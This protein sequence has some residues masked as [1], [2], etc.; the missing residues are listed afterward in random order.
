MSSIGAKARQ[1]IRSRRS[2]WPLTAI[3]SG[4]EKYLR[5]YYNDSFFD[6]ALNGEAYVINSYKEL[7]GGKDITIW[8]IGANNGQWAEMI[9]NHFPA[10]KIISFEI[11]PQIA[12]LLNKKFADSEWVEIHNLGLSDS[13]DT[14]DVTYNHD[15]NTTSAINPRMENQFFDGKALS[16]VPCQVTTVDNLIAK[17]LTSPD[18]IKIDVEGHE[19]PVLRGAEKLLRS[20]NGPRLIQFEYG[21]TWLP[22]N[23]T[24]CR[25][26][27]FLEECGYSVGRIYPNHV[28]FQPYSSKMDHFR[29][30]NMV[31]TNDPILLKKLANKG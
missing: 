10:A 12:A 31:A 24:L 14:I 5:A 4:C 11:I 2:Q 19:G 15:F 29:M 17:G 22:A 26:Q 8:D 6:F 3:A 21:D 28:D 20:D 25:V 9:H 18:F 27:K 1:F 16:I 23:E 7:Q 13:D 30:G